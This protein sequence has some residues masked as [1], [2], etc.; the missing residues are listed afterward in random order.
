MHDAQIHYKYPI[1]GF[2]ADKKPF[3]KI[4]VYEPWII[5]QASNVLREGAVFGVQMQPYDAHISW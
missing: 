3:I 4:E 2:C 5:K 1:Y